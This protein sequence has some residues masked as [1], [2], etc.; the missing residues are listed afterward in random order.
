[1]DNYCPYRY[2][3]QIFNG[4]DTGMAWCREDERPCQ[5]EGDGTCRMTREIEDFLS[6]PSNLEIN[7]T[8]E[9]DD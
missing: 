4:A 2:F 1:M 9:K 7:N 6:D 3:E 5:Q 8:E